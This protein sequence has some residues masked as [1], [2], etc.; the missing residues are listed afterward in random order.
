MSTNPVLP[1]AMGGPPSGGLPFLP[2]ELPLIVRRRQRTDPCI[3]G[4]SESRSP[5][6]A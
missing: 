2:D 4:W 1:N 3:F 6:S 5:I